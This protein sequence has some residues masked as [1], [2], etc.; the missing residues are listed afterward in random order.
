MSACRTDCA[1]GPVPT[2]GA[3]T[4]RQRWIRFA[5][6]VALGTLRGLPVPATGRRRQRALVCSAAA[7]LSAL[8]VRVEVRAP[9]TGWPRGAG[10]LVV[11]NHISWLDDLALLTAVPGVPVAK[12]EVAGWPVIG[13]L[14]HRANTIFLDRARI[15]ALPGTV[16]DVAD[17]LRG[18][19]NVLVHPE[20]TTSCG[21][22]LDRFRPAF[23]QAAI[24]ADASVCPVAIRYRTGDAS[25]TAVA[26][27]VSGDSLLRS[28]R[29]VIAT[30]GL[31]VEVHLLPAL[32]P[33]GADRRTLAALSEYAVAEVVEARGPRGV[34]PLVA[35]RPPVP[36]TGGLRPVVGAA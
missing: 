20:G 6:A 33:A 15:R 5:G 27:Y 9:A 10:R 17:R 24:D 2:V 32:T 8:G 30:R 3:P 12:E 26:S 7:V 14:L 16:A 18:G 4:R 11:S 22:R 25:A 13:R 1:E 29:R 28:I 34:H 35:R 31:V 21:A 19:G 23:F 36:A